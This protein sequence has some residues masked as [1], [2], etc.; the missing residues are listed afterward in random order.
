M[1]KKID[2]IIR[3]NLAGERGA[4]SIYKTQ[5]KFCT[6]ENTKHHI[7]HCLAEEQNHLLY[8]EQQAKERNI[9]PTLLEPLWKLGS[10]SLGALSTLLGQK[11]IMVATEAVEEVIVEHYKEQ[12]V[13]LKQNFSQE[14]ELIKNLE[15]FCQEEE[16]HKN[17]AIDFGSKNMLGYDIFYNVTKIATKLAINIAKKI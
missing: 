11:A 8:F 15:Q 12:I 13:E 3:V 2:E 17:E 5:Q 6:N 14:I 9:R 10:F 1:S 16:I 4:V 7:E